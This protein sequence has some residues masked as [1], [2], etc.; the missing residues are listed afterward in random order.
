[1]CRQLVGQPADLAP[2]HRI[3]LPGYRERPHA[4]LA[5]ASGRQMHVDDRVGLVHAAGRLIDALR[6][7][8]HAAFGACEHPEEFA[9]QRFCYTAQLSNL[10][11]RAHRACRLERCRKTFHMR[12]DVR[13][14]ERILAAQMMQQAV[15]QISIRARCDRQ[16]QIGEVAGGCAAR[17]D[18][19]HLHF[20]TCL[21]CRG[22]SLI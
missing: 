22:Q 21:F 9:D 17:I 6:E 18:H 11:Y 8:R 13:K 2:A 15:E 4:R 3:R 16:M 20:R 12:F 19:H 1:M 7:D 5:Y 14:I 10:G